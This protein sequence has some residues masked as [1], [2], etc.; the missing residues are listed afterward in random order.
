MFI[1]G[2]NLGYSRYNK[3]IT[4]TRVYATTIVSVID[5]L[6]ILLRGRNI[7]Y[8]KRPSLRG[9]SRSNGACWMPWRVSPTVTNGTDRKRGYYFLMLP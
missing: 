5:A 4:L 6:A 7:F 2:T 8:A 1:C 9:Y 3:E